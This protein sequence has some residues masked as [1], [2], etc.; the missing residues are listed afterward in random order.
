[1]CGIN[2]YI[3]KTNSKN[4][5]SIIHQMNKILI[6]RG[7]D[8]RGLLVKNNIALGMQRLSIIDIENGVQPM[9]NI[10]KSISIVF[11]GEIYNH[12]NLRKDL[13]SEGVTFKTQSDTE[14]I[15]KLYELY[16]I[17][18]FSMLDGMFAFSIISFPFRFPSPIISLI[19]FYSTFIYIGSS[20][21]TASHFAL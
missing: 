12:K 13:I 10:D 4:L 19:H 16:G 6:H 20:S 17:K 2:G 8:D 7:P 15:I 11:N 18:S 9:Q 21:M 3:D 14:V 1:M 5:N